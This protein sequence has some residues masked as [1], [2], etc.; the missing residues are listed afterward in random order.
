MNRDGVL[1]APRPVITHVNISVRYASACR[2]SEP[3]F[4]GLAYDT[5]AAHSPI[6]SD[7]SSMRAIASRI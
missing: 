3:A 4:H 1:S 2:N 6:V 7:H 5:N